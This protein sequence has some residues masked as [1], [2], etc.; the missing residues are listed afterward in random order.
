MTTSNDKTFY[1]LHTT[2]LGYLNRVRE[3]KPKKADP[4]LACDIKAL[5]GASDKLSYVRFDAR[6]SGTEAQHLIRRCAN[7]VKAEKK[8]LIG[9]RV[10]DL[11]GDIFTHTKGK[12]TGEQD[13]SFKVRLLFISWIK[14]DGV[15][16]YK[17]E[18]KPT[19]SD[20]RES[21]I[22]S[23]E[24]PTPEEAPAP[25]SPTPAAEAAIEAPELEA[26]ESF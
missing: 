2:G 23:P 12:K 16:V 15:L 3:V 25:A 17:A 22:P 4:F 9:F 8:V 26:A 6:V 10:G 1:N 11:W 20:E 5:N 21:D 7:A 19:D 24:T 13:V 18:P 14:V